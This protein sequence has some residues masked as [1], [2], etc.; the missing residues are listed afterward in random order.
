MCGISNK[1]IAA[2]FKFTRLKF[3]CLAICEQVLIAWP[4]ITTNE[5]LVRGQKHW[6][7]LIFLNDLGMLWADN[8]IAK[9][10]NGASGKKY[11][12]NNNNNGGWFFEPVFTCDVSFRLLPQIVFK[13]LTITLKTVGP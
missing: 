3:I 11:N 13:D 9:N 6:S 10:T 2:V 8:R 12:N 7:D 1:Q 4:R 5:Q